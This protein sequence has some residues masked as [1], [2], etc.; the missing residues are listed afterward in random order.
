MGGNMQEE[1]K[2]GFV[3]IRRRME[4]YAWQVFKE[5]VLPEDNAFDLWVRDCMKLSNSLKC[6]FFDVYENYLLEV[7]LAENFLLEKNHVKNEIELDIQNNLFC[8]STH[9]VFIKNPR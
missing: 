9:L 7:D 4:T 6:S 1:L 5:T 8:E 2:P 3:K